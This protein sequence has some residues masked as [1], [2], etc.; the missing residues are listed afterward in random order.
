MAVT[1]ARAAVKKHSSPKAASPAR[2]VARRHSKKRAAGGKRYKYYEA[3]NI[4]KKPNCTVSRAKTLS[5]RRACKGT[6][7][8]GSKKCVRIAGGK[9]C[10]YAKLLTKAQREKIVKRFQ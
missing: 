10:R 9:R 4:R 3:L 8:K 6:A 1:R 5:G 2:T 7:G